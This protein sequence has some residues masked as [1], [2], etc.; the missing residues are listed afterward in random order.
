MAMDTII[1]GYVSCPSSQVKSS[2]ALSLH[3]LSSVDR[4]LRQHRAVSPLN[5][6]AHAFG[7]LEPDP[8]CLGPKRA[9]RKR[10]A[11]TEHTFV[12]TTREDDGRRAT[13]S[14]RHLLVKDNKRTMIKLVPDVTDR[15]FHLLQGARVLSCPLL[16]Q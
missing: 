13:C 15:W 4:L 12:D 2:Q 9:M 14:P 1:R 5:D 16:I 10:S 8:L 3:P 7:E 11:A 6:S